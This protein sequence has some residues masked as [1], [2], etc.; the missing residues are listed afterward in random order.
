MQEDIKQG[1]DLA[2]LILM[3]RKEKFFLLQAVGFLLCGWNAVPSPPLAWIIFAGASSLCN[4]FFFFFFWPNMDSS[5]CCWCPIFTVPFVKHPTKGH[6]K[7]P[8]TCRGC[9][10][11]PAILHSTSYLLRVLILDP[12]R[13]KKWRS[14]GLKEKHRSYR[15]TYKNI[16]CGGGMLAQ[17]GLSMTSSCSC[18]RLNPDNARLHNLAGQ[19]VR[20]AWNGKLSISLGGNVDPKKALCSVETQFW[21]VKTRKVATWHAKLWRKPARYTVTN[22]RNKK[23]SRSLL[24]R[25]PVALGQSH[26]WRE[27]NTWLY[28]TATIGDGA[29]FYNPATKSLPP[30]KTSFPGFSNPT[31]SAGSIDP[32][33][34]PSFWRKILLFQRSWSFIFLGEL[35]LEVPFKGHLCSPWGCWTHFASVWGLTF[36]V[37][38]TQA[39]KCSSWDL[40]PDR[41]S[42]VS[43]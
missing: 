12:Q 29:R 33:K 32:E 36:G 30:E 8:G 11:L 25:S 1:K 5:C 20:N 34:R 9:G 23:S 7:F 40:V 18:A 4:P 16:L 26:G 27:G 43:P 14:N 19:P 24:G 2:G 31:F 42:E 38:F 15:I 21:E 22:P 6:P 3:N 37:S 13:K 41:V 28:T 17:K 35:F 39:R 10:T